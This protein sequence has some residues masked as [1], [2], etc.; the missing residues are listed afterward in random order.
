MSSIKNSLRRIL[1]PSNDLFTKVSEKNAFQYREICQ[2]INKLDKNFIQVEGKLDKL[3]LLDNLYHLDKLHLLDE[4]THLDK[5]E[6]LDK[7]EHLDKLQLLDR[8]NHLNELQ[9]LLVQLSDSLLYKRHYNNDHER[10]AIETW[11]YYSYIEQDS[12]ED[13][14]LALIKDIDLASIATINQVLGRMQLIKEI[15]GAIDLYTQDEQ[16]L[17]EKLND[18]F[19]GQIFKVSNSLYAYHDYIL[20]IKCF[21]A[22]VF[23]EKHGIK[24]VNNV[25]I[26]K[27]KDII[28]VGGFIGDSAL[29]L[30]P[31]TD[32]YV[33]SF[34]ALEENYKL[35]QKTLHLNNLKN[36]VAENL[37][38]G[39]S[40]EVLEISAVALA[41]A[42]F[43]KPVSRV[44]YIENVSIITLDSYVIKHDLNVGLIKVDIEGFEQEF[45]KGAEKTIKKFKP[46]LFISIYHNPNDFFE[47]K[48]MIESWNLGYSFKFYKPFDD[49]ILLGTTLIAEVL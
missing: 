9:Q 33:Y 24:H 3:Q 1:P 22:G 21:E 29:I 7:L 14:Y 5:L 17:F 31:L 47:I 6:Y 8:L 48:P 35:M 2:A 20:P 10:K 49:S 40:E 15:N 39:S 13:K 23:F 26:I 19:Y 32:K 30:A 28:D 27:N 42:T 41:S 11:G 12:F 38:L 34:E 18:D 43:G 37:G 45:L 25:N 46:V 44:K 4:L 16:E 36:V